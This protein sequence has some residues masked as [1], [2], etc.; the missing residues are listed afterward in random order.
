LP[1]GGAPHL[2]PRRRDEQA[3]QGLA[4]THQRDRH[5]PAGPPGNEVARAVDRVHQPAKPALEPFGVVDGLLGQPAGGGE[6]CAELA[7]QEGVDREIG[8]AY[9]AAGHLLP[10]FERVAV[11]GPL[12]QR[13]L[14][15]LAADVV[16]TLAVNH[17][18]GT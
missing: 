18:L 12:P 3:D 17:R 6:Q 8:G 2:V 5:R 13:H 16:E 15:G 1:G 14:A 10:A 11:A 9:R 7:A 4:G